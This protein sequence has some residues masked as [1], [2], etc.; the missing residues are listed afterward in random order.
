MCFRVGDITSRGFLHRPADEATNR[1]GRCDGHVLAGED[2]VEGVGQI[3]L[4]ALGPLVTNAELVVDAT[5]I[6]DSSVSAE[7]ECLGSARRA[8]LIRDG[9]LS[10]LE[11][12][13]VN[14]VNARVVADLEQR[15]LRVGI[16]AEEGDVS[17]TILAFQFAEP[18][19]V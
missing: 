4:H 6:E 17:I 5:P 19:A 7:D 14:L 18:A 3:G 2:F 15:I 1:L 12:G 16:D 8:K 13:K 9:C 11:N 10:V